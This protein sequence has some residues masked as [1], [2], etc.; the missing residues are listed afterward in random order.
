MY[1]YYL[2]VY[3]YASNLKHY[4]FRE[5]DKFHN[6]LEIVSFPFI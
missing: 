2:P 6:N 4:T 1:P 3:S 5:L